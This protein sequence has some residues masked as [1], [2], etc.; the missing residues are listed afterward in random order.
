[1]CM[2]VVLYALLSTAAGAAA[3]E[4]LT[5]LYTG[6]MDGELEPCGCSPK[7]DFGGLARLSG[8][9]AAHSDAL[10]PY[11]LVDAG[12]FT[13]KDTPQGRLKA[14]AFLKSFSVMKYDAVA[15]S[16]REKSFSGDFFPPL[17]EKYNVP[18]L[19]GDVRGPQSILI[20]LGSTGV[21]VSTFPG[22]PLDGMVNI[23]LT[24]TPVSQAE[25]VKGWDIVISSSGTTYLGV[26]GCAKCHQ[27]FVESWEKTRHA[28]AFADLEKAGKAS[29]PEC[30]V[31]HSV[32]YGEPGGFFNIDTTPELANVQCEECHGLDREH[33]NDF[34]RPMMP[35]TEDVC[36]KC[37]TTENSPDFDYPVYLEK[38]KH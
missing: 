4:T 10:S 23:L 32:G 37:H 3:E 8:Y 33:I 28:R 5:V 18:V 17:V 11:V 19:P 29:D 9:I 22:R 6:G 35:V 34:S 7:T 25:D 14:E 1:V 27:V 26:A 2:A 16:G 12:N 20:P 31:C 21:H 24:G 38:I 15:F 13:D 36:L 30:V